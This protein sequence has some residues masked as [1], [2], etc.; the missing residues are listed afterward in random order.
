MKIP[1]RYIPDAV[2]RLV[3]AY[4][5]ERSPD[6][7][8]SPWAERVGSPHVQELLAEYKIV[9]QFNQDPMAFVDW[10]QT[11]LFTLDDMGEGECAV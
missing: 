6:E 7:A 5:D 2:E 11:K 1:A 3:G 8:F 4:V 10:G 9:P